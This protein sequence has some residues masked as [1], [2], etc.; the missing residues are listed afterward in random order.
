[1]G[2]GYP[3][4]RGT[5]ER[6][7]SW[8]IVTYLYIQYVPAQHTQQSNAINAVRGDKTVMLH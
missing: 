7:M 3:T 1:M 6:G 8:P 5:F 4:E 2:F